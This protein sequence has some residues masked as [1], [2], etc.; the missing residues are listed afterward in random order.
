MRVTE[1][2]ADL[3][4]RNVENIS[5]MSSKFNEAKDQI[6]II[7]CDIIRKIT[8]LRNDV[9]VSNSNSLPIRAAARVIEEIVDNYQVKQRSGELISQKV[10]HS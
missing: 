9:H 10:I 3:I 7:E 8:V 4:K 1:H 6:T 5:N 2:W